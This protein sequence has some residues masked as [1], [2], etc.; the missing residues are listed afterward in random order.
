MSKCFIKIFTI[1]YL[2][3]LSIQVDENIYEIKDFRS[4]PLVI[5][6]LEEG[7]YRVNLKIPSDCRVLSYAD[8]NNDK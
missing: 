3:I 6:K 7:F 1:F 2:I 8:F 4:N 5:G